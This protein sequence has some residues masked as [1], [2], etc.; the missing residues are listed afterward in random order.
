MNIGK[1]SNLL[2]ES[3]QD[4]ENRLDIKGQNSDLWRIS[5]LRPLDFCGFSTGS[6]TA[7]DNLIVQFRHSYLC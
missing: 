1:I 5:F 6:S 7:V 3:S 4:V 2:T